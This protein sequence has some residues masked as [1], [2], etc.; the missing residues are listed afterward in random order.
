MSNAVPKRIASLPEGKASYECFCGTV[1][2]AKA[3]AVESGSR[4]SCKCLYS[5]PKKHGLRFHPLYGRWLT[6]K[7]R[8]YND[9]CVA[10]WRYGAKGIKV[11]REWKEN[12][13]AFIEWAEAAGWKPGLTVDRLDNRKGYSP[14]NCRIATYQQQ[15]DNK[16]RYANS[17]RYPCVYARGGRWRAVVRRCGISHHLGTF[18]LARDANAAVLLFKRS[19]A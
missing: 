17:G 12:P 10:Y 15:A 2:V 16:R 8:C 18:D 6:M 5:K 3:G 19:A 14:S 9:R 1:F 13:A 11:C 7:S 4:K